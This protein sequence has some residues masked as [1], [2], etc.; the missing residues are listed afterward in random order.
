MLFVIVNILLMD[1][2]KM[3]QLTAFSLCRYALC[4]YVYVCKS[5]NK[6][7]HTVVYLQ[8]NKLQKNAVNFTATKQ[9]FL[10]YIYFWTI[11]NEFYTVVEA[12]MYTFWWLN[13][14]LE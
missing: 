11:F 3:L 14:F 12:K 6:L 2:N 7:D 1:E 10:Y 9:L 13:F 8:Y 5:L 4:I